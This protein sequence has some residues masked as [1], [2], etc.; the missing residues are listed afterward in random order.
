M[1]IT[2]QTYA[3]WIEEN[4]EYT[5]KLKLDIEYWQKILKKRVFDGTWPRTI[6]AVTDALQHQI[7]RQI[8]DCHY[9]IDRIK[10]EKNAKPCQPQP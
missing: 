1:N 3:D 2:Q 5:D 6:K 8:E 10:E 4:L 9:Y 7:V